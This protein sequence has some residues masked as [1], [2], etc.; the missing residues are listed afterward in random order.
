MKNKI[1]VTALLVLVLCVSCNSE[2][3]LEWFKGE[4]ENVTPVNPNV[5]SSY[6]ELSGVDG[7]IVPKNYL[8]LPKNLVIPLVVEDV[9]VT[10]VTECFECLVEY[11]TVP[12]GIT[13]GVNCFA[14]CEQLNTIVLSSG[15][16]SVEDAAFADCPA[17]QRVVVNCSFSAVSSAA[18]SSDCMAQFEYGGNTYDGFVNFKNQS[19]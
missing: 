7:T 11:L 4:V 17:L 14:D 13:V 18:F 5:H 1:L 10:K 16:V 2:K 6:F 12:G 8:D 15:V 19:L 9:N 3:G